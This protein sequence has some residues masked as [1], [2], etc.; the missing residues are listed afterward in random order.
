MDL[1]RAARQPVYT[2]VADQIQQ[3]IKA[4]TL[5]PGDQ[6]LPE[7]QLAEL[8][9]VSRPSVREALALLVGKGVIAVS[10][11]DGA[12]IRRTRLEDMVEPLALAMLQERQQIHHLF[13]VRQVIE[14][15]A[16]HL[17]AQ[18]RD[19]DDIRRLRLLGQRVATDVQS[20][21]PADAT[22]TLFHVGIVETAKNPLLT[23]VMGTLI[24]AMMEVYSPARRRIL[25][26]PTDAPTFLQEHEQIIDAIAAQ[27][28]DRAAHMVTQH[29][30]HAQRRLEAEEQGAV[31]KAREAS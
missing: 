18:R 4:G 22:D 13:E 21:S 19:I 10:P 6:L 9:Q 5:A 20:G 27:D 3:L 29:L 12:Y 26:D 17:A 11:R 8:L 23:N 7:R 24:V 31:A 2:Q 16:A 14:T 28:P 25:A 15:Q 30:A 1:K